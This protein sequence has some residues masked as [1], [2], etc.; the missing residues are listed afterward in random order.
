MT[1]FRNA[2]LR[3]LAATLVIGAA[4]AFAH[5]GAVANGFVYLDDPEYV[6]ANPHVA[7]GIT[8]EGVLW[9]FEIE[10]RT[11]YFHPLTWLSLMLDAE[12]FGVDP[13][14]FHL[15]NVLLHLVNALLLFALLQGATGRSWPS[16][17]AAL[18]WA[19]HPLGVEAVAWVTERKAVL[20][21]TFGLG[22]MLAHISHARRPSGWKVVATTGLV[23]CGLLAKIALVVLPFLL[24]VLDFWPLRRLDPS[25]PAGQPG[26][27]GARTGLRLLLE[28]VPAV[29]AGIVV[30][31][32]VIASL[33]DGIERKALVVPLAD[34]IAIGVA[35]IP[36]YLTA[37]AWPSDL[38]VIHPY[39]AAVDGSAFAAGCLTV[40]VLSAVAVALARRFPAVLAGWSWFL[41]AIAPYLG[42]LQSG[43]WPEWA[44]RFAYVPMIGLTIAIAYV[45]AELASLMPSG[46]L[47]AAGAG[48]AAVV[49]LV[50]ATREQVQVWRSPLDLFTH[51]VT[52]EPR[53]AVLHSNRGKALLDA[54][55]VEDAKAAFGHALSL[56]P[57]L[58]WANAEMASLLA[59]EGEQE[60]A[61]HHFLAALRSEPD[62]PELLFNYAE[63][64]KA[65]GDVEGARRHYVRFLG[66]VNYVRGGGGLLHRNVGDA[67]LALGRT[68]DAKDAFRRM[69]AADPRSAI[70]QAQLGTILMREGLYAE[71]ERHLRI[72]VQTDPELLE[73]MFNYAEVLRVS[74]QID[75][76]R[77]YY[78][79]FAA[80]APPRLEA[81]RQRALRH[82]RRR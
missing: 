23:L 15:T 32:L 18:L 3:A 36:R 56:D 55:R 57:S 9:A 45:T 47:I 59:K 30:M 74:N 77:P 11:T 6:T 48:A 25:R 72:A 65:R 54:G 41:L 69:I 66:T 29:L 52:V 79:R 62:M 61:N 44:E 20:S 58:A 42:I 14:G 19:V 17:A 71:A 53:V 40:L 33:K 26:N 5:G 75:S 2:R 67:L 10:D 39:P 22:A 76:A 81:E 78:A 8:A 51:A 60:R 80:Q 63:F 7:A 27:D 82:L 35:A 34:R 49:A 43:I 68:E 12:L 13:R 24:L 73:A 1:G 64:S 31:G 4:V 37:F 70:A 38:A 16:F 50:Q 46:R 21:T 28:K